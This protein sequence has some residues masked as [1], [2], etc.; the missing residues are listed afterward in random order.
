[1][2]KG[3]NMVSEVTKSKMNSRAIKLSDK[4]SVDS[5]KQKQ[6]HPS[7]VKLNKEDSNRTEE[8][9]K[10]KPWVLYLQS[11][12]IPICCHTHNRISS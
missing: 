5:L 11:L 1:M 10:S 2:D 7:P 3:E 8:P 6:N 9:K 4:S 12:R